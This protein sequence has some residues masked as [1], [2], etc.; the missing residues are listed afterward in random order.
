M[1]VF[2]STWCGRRSSPVSLSSMKLLAPRAWCERRMLR[3]EGEVFRLGTAIVISRRV[4]RLRPPED[5]GRREPGCMT[6]RRSD[7]KPELV[8]P[9]RIVQLQEHAVRIF[10]EDLLQVDDLHVVQAVRQTVFLDRRP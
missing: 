7:I 10:H 8:L 2:R 1:P 9:R 3:R 5:G 4:K 6:Q